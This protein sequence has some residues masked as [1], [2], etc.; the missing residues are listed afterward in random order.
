MEKRLEDLEQD[1]DALR[2]ATIASKER[3]YRKLVLKQVQEVFDE[4]SKNEVV[5]RI[6]CMDN[7]YDCS[8]RKFCKNQMQSK[9]EAISLAYM[10]G[11]YDRAISM[12]DEIENGVR[13]LG[14][15][16]ESG[17]CQ[18]YVLVLISEIRT[19]LTLAIRIEKKAGELPP[20][21]VPTQ[22]SPLDSV[23]ASEAL[24]PLAHPARLDILAHLENGEMGFSE[25]SKE[26]GMKTGH[27]QFHL[28]TLEKGGYVRKDRKGGKYRISLQGVTALDGLRGFMYNLVRV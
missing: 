24:A 10:S 23:T 11:D 28:K 27:L 6:E 7:I 5:D 3:E 8:K 20:N 13:G 18:K 15:D 12:L 4:F 22:A 19:V 14:S 9:V 21:V 16:C 25:L 1:F 2:A 17:Q 26:L